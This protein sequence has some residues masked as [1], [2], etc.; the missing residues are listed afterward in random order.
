MQTISG[1]K[2]NLEEALALYRW[3]RPEQDYSFAYLFLKSIGKGTLLSH[4]GP[5]TTLMGEDK[6]NIII[7]TL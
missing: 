4:H 1:E 7:S 6:F 5:I 3:T 2:V